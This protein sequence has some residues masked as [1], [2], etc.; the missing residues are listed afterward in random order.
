MS[1]LGHS[2]TFRGTIA[3]SALP[4][5]ADVN[6]VRSSVGYGPKAD[7]GATLIHQLFD[8]IVDAA[9]QRQRYGDPE[10]LGGVEVDE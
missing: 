9:E 2:P 7:L 5:K 3:M 10:R 8:H 4:L 6:R 1:A